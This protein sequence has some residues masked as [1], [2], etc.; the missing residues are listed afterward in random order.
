MSL[1]ISIFTITSLCFYTI[2]TP[3]VVYGCM[4]VYV[5]LCM[6]V[7]AGVEVV[8]AF[9]SVHVHVYVA[10]LSYVLSVTV[11]ER[12]ILSDFQMTSVELCVENKTAI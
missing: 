5:L 2:S 3:Y 7:C 1:R 6:G 9:T 12:E 8:Y 10:T 4:C 11:E